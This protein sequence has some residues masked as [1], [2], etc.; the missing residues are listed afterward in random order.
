MNDLISVIVP[1][2]NV[3]Q[4]LEKC[5][6]SL[7][8]Q[9]YKN[10]EI[11]LVDDGS[12]DKSSKICDKY[13]SQ[14]NRIKVIHKQNGGISSA[15]N[16][17]MNIAKG[18]YYSFVDADD[19]VAN[20]F[21]E[22]LYTLL[23]K[24]NADISVCDY[25]RIYDYE[26]D[27]P[28]IQEVV[29]EYTNDTFAPLFNLKTHPYAVMIWNKLYIRDLFDGIE[30]LEGM[31]HEDEELTYRVCDKSKKIVFT[32][33]QLY[34]YNQFNQSSFMHVFNKKRLD[35]FYHL[36]N[37][38]KLYKTKDEKLYFDTI[39]LILFRVRSSYI[40]ALASKAD[41]SVFKIIKDTF[42][43]YYLIYKGFKGKY[44]IPLSDKISNFC[45][46]Y[47]KPLFILRNLHRIIK[48]KF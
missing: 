24:Y 36:S 40:F 43:E 38:A 27:I 20:D 18:K 25:I 28:E 26:F 2:F 1:I 14:D 35:L 17:G 5:I 39:A 15:R 33:R 44:D 31:V 29:T 9:T 48:N 11:I 42:K 37:R 16:T 30:F 46:I 6:N 41:K 22:S 10:I 8:N 21:Y 23:K 32:N 7:I 19:M 34:Y 13:A 45:F 12:T 3:E 47:F 4:Y